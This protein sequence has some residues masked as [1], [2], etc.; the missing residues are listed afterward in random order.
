MKSKLFTIRGAASVGLVSAA[1]FTA[2]VFL[3]AGRR[4]TPAS[5]AN[6]VLTIAADYRNFSVTVQSLGEIDA[7]RSN[8]LLSQVRGDRG[9]IIYLVDDGALVQQDQVLVRLDPTP[10]E[11]EVRQAENKL[12]ECEAIAEGQEQLLEFEKNEGEKEV[13]AAEYDLR[14]SQLELV[15]LKEGDS[16]IEVA[17]LESAVEDAVADHDKKRS[18]QQDLEALLKKGYAYPGEIANAQK[19]VDKATQVMQ[20][21][22]RQLDGYRGHVLPAMLERA[23]LAVVKAT[24]NYSQTDKSVKFKIARQSVT[25]KQARQEIQGAQSALSA[26]RRQLD[27]TIIRAP[28]PG[29]VVLREEFVGGQKRK[30]RVGDAV[31]QNQP[32]VYL[33]DVSSMIVKTRVREVDLHK[34]AVG[35]TATITLEAY[36]DLACQG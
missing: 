10:Y 22:K 18:Y 16:V 33:P 12:A 35:M 32:L 24:M 14:I 31:W 21:A 5:T 4:T 27:A 26:A 11:E 3:L 36:P 20:T 13:R 15:K 23:E 30:P 17:R 34:I 25:L 19:A 29:M 2:I 8:V 1:A 9:R 6:G 28:I 7:S